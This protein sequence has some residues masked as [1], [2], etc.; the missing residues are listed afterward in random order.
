MK[1]VSMSVKDNVLTV[2]IDLSKR[3]GP[4]ASGKSI[5]IASTEGNQSVPGQEEIKVGVNV[6][7]KE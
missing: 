4:S 5:I 2:S 1:N 6:Y 3:F 7:T